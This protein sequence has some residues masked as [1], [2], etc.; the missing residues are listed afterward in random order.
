MSPSNKSSTKN[1]TGAKVAT[2]VKKAQSPMAIVS[3]YNNSSKVKSTVLEKKQKVHNI[4]PLQYSDETPFGWAFE[5]FYD[6]KEFLKSLCKNDTTYLGG[7]EFKPFSNLTVHWVKNSALG[8]NL[9]IIHIDAETNDDEKPFPIQCHVLFAN[10]I[11]RVLLHHV[12]WPKEKVKVHKSIIM[13]RSTESELTLIIDS[14]NRDNTE[15][16]I[17]DSILPGKSELES[18]I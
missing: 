6:A 1:T 7:E 11:A 17:S 14:D 3:P 2:P 8:V 15:V 13:D 4:I 5:H 12:P 18:L 9:W 10:K 16:T